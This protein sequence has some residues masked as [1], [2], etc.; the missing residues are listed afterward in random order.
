MP[1]IKNIADKADIISMGMPSLMLMTVYIC[2]E[3]YE[4][5]PFP[6]WKKGLQ[7]VWN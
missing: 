7:E 4:N 6:D 5:P 1:D 2:Q 3:L